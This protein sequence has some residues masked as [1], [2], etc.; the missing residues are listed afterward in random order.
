MGGYG[1]V[2]A[3]AERTMNGAMNGAGFGTLEYRYLNSGAPSGSYRLQVRLP[4]S[5]GT[6]YVT[7]TL[8]GQAWAQISED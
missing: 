2:S 1:N 3:A 8:T 6:I 7:T 5:S 4:I